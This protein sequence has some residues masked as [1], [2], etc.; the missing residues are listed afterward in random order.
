MKRLSVLLFLA[1]IVTLF[2]ISCSKQKET[3][4]TPTP[5]V[6]SMTTNLELNFNT[7]IFTGTFQNG[8][9][10]SSLTLMLK[11]GAEEY[12]PHTINY[13]KNGF[14]FTLNNLAFDTYTY[15]YEYVADGETKTTGERSFSVLVGR[16]RT[17]DNGH[18]EVYNADGTGH[19][20][21]PSEDVQE[22]EADNFDWSVDENNKLTQIVHFQGGQGDVPQY[23]NILI[24][25]E[26]TL[27]YNNEGW[28]AE[29][30][31]TRVN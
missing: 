14:S 6:F 30:T 21:D 9:K 23:C 18:Y 20:W 17:E 26:T 4:V 12:E 16:W 8:D 27:K 13:N 2:T 31:L 10:L 29:Y 7:G 25:T 15:F 3:P 1:L 24:L 5:K 28:R 11:K 22:D 19:M